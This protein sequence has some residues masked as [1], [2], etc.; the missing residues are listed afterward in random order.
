MT[1]LTSKDFDAFFGEIHAS[2]QQ[3]LQPFPWQRRLVRK[4]LGEDGEPGGWPSVLALPT[5]SGKTAC[6]D[7]AVFTLACQADRPPE[8]RVAPRRIFFVVDRRVIV[9][10]AYEHARELARCLAEAR[11]GVLAHVADR[12]RRL[13]DLG[14]EATPLAAYELRGGIYRD[15]AWARTPTQPTILTST[16]DQVGSRLLYRGYGVSSRSWPIHAGLA[17]HDALVILDEAHCA[18]PFGET[19]AAVDGYRRW[20]SAPVPSPFAQVAM[21]ATPRQG[22]PEEE[23]FRLAPEDRSDPELG[24]RLG[25]N[26]PATLL[27]P[28]AGKSGGG[29]FVRAL[30]QQ[31]EAFEA[32]GARRIA[33]LVNRVATARQVYEQLSDRRGDRVL[34]IGRMRPWDRDR[35]LGRWRRHLAA[36]TG[37]DDHERPIFVVAT[38]CL[39]VGA[40]LDF[41]AMVTE[42][43]SLDALRQRFGRLNRLGQ[44]EEAQAAVAVA[45]DDLKS[46]QEDF[47]YGAALRETWGFL[48]R[49]AEPSSAGAPVI[50]FGI[51]RFDRLW[52]EA[53]RSD[54]DLPNRLA[55]PAPHAPVM[56]PAH[57]DGW[58]QT[59]P[60]PAPDPDVSP[61]LHGENRGAPEVQ[62]CW[63]RDL[64]VPS[65]PRPDFESLL[66][67]WRNTVA[68]IPPSSPECMPVPLHTVRRW[69][70]GADDVGEDLSDVE[71]STGRPEID[72]RAER[73]TATARPVLRWRGPEDSEIAWYGR[74][75][76]PGDT[77]VI[78]A[79]LGGWD[80]FGHIPPRDEGHQLVDVAEPANLERRRRAVL[81]LHPALLAQ[82]PSLPDRDRAETL[83]G[84]SEAAADSGDFRAEIETLV[85]DLAAS[86]DQVPELQEVFRDLKDL[87]FDA[88]PHASGEGWLL[89][90]RGVRPR[91]ST[92]DGLVL[93][94]PE[95]FTSDDD[96]ASAT[97][98][99]RLADH[100]D[101]VADLAVRFG[102]SC[103]LPGGLV[104]DL[105]LAG[106]LHDLGKADPRFQAWLFGGNALAA[107]LAPAPL[108]K[109]SGL[110]DDA[111][112]RER[113][114][115]RAGYPRG[116][117]HELLSVRLAES[118]GAKL[119]AAASDPEL[120][121]H[122]VASHHG[123]CRPLA[124][125]IDDDHPVEVRLEHDG[126]V[127]SAPAAT[128]LER[129]DS[130]VA[131]RF[132]RLVERYGWWGVAFFEALFRL[133]DHRWSEYEERHAEP[134]EEPQRRA[135]S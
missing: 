79:A 38:Q 92:S 14:P 126:M 3:R 80:R 132:W 51:D 117:R 115:R 58:V 56:L 11:K 19:L 16:V 46:G 37:R 8:E 21:T 110:A 45:A 89:R 83:A 100:C 107:Q 10:E 116:A 122:L 23:V 78:P 90:A 55:S 125:V 76:R 74:Q 111:R 131:E 33:V 52:A 1:E 30:C 4:I 112:E 36:G 75:L 17:A 24:R 67:L 27:S 71:G 62:V 41:D 70:D 77:V 86:A 50:D 63:R 104:D 6:L 134:S 61:F 34:M 43:A 98:D 9:D 97:A 99:V 81:R 53:V 47:V 32:A 42:C 26:R 128:A 20:A 127:L 105:R 87:G 118:G 85:E 59:A 133:S 18:R 64:E 13:A 12:L 7:V 124:P 96:S 102:E 48:N 54:P 119:L 91:P 25:A 109:S 108:A 2:G 49:H 114:R 84:W 60:A 35:L 82:W 28:I 123:H 120:V 130:G 68:A 101:G 72:D 73:P 22:T 121:L 93:P 129:L 103:G 88:R 135:R 95:T 39:E 40:N 29:R 66:G 69:L 106:R 113:A 57:V 5:A 94:G 44:D 15:D 65:D 31:A